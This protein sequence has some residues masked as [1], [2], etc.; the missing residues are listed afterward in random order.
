MFVQLIGFVAAILTTV[1]YIPQVI[2]I[3]RTRETRS[4]SLP[5][6]LALSFGILLWIIYG[7]IIL[8]WPLIIANSI[9]FILV[10]TILLLKI[11][12]G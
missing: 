5:M 3:W 12:H 10:A 8:A 4:I 1:S 9:S 11:K 2:Q 7:V 6:Y